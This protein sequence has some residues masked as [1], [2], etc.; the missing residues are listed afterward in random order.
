[1]ADLCD[2][3]HLMADLC[4]VTDLMA[5]VSAYARSALSDRHTPLHL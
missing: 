3:T 2:V 5:A 1:M 4:D